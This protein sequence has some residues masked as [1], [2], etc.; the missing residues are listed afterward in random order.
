[1]CQC[2]CGDFQATHRFAG[3][4]GITYAFKAHPGCYNCGIPAGAIVYR[5]DAEQAKEWDLARLPELPFVSYA[6]DPA[7]RNG[8]FAHAVADPEIIVEKLTERFGAFK[9]TDE[10]GDEWTLAETLEDE[11]REIVDDAIHETLRR[12]SRA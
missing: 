4:D 12:F 11:G 10:D 7:D 1:M 2:G 3:P 6:S 8:E 5:F 9:E